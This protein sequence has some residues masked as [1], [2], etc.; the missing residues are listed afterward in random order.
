MLRSLHGFGNVRPLRLNVGITDSLPKLVAWSWELLGRP[1]SSNIS[2][3]V[4]TQPARS[5]SD[6][7][8]S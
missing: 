5:I 7:C 3:S 2:S 8:Q 6:Y 1:T 4:K